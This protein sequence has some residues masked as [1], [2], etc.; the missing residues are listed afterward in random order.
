MGK[1]PEYTFNVYNS[2]APSGE[3]VV[4]KRMLGKP[5]V[6]PVIACIGSDL[7]VG[8]SLGPIVGT[9]LIEKLRHLN[10]YVY[11]C[12]AKP[13]TAHEIRY[14][15]EFIRSTHPTSPIIAVDAAVGAAGDVGLIKIVKGGLRPGSGANKKL[16]KVGDVSIMGIV[17]E[18]SMFNYSLFS[19][20]RL[21]LVY[22]MSQIISDGIADYIVELLTGNKKLSEKA[23]REIV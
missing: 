9:K 15:N 19:S 5:D 16:T 7:S 2:L 11:G 13:L 14:T 22:K 23:E 20:T 3:V 1:L 10:V 12:L 17:A 6:A 18:K 21:N 8:D 4:L